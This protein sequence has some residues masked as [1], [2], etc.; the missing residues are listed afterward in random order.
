MYGCGHAGG[1]G[2]LWAVTTHIRSLEDY[3][4]LQLT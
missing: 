3:T 1:G 4:V 2:V